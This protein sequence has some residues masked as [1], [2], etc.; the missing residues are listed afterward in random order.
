VQRHDPDSAFSHV[1]RMFSLR[2]RSP[3]LAIGHIEELETD[4]SEQVFAALRHSEAWTR[5]AVVAFNFSDVKRR[6]RLRLADASI[7]RFRNYLSGEMLEARGDTL[8][9][10]LR[11]YGYKLLEVLP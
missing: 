3:E 9:L 5:R 2:A 10:D 7:R 6:V 8:N 4:S 11:T 1:R